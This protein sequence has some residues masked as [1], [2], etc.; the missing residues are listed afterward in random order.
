MADQGV[1]T[2]EKVMAT[3]AAVLASSLGFI[4]G[5][6]LPVAMPAIRADLGASFLASQWIA[7]GYMLFLS[8]LVLVGGAAGD[9]FG[10]REAFI[11]GILVFTLASIGCAIAGTAELLILFRCLQG[12]G[13]AVMVPGSLAL[14]ARV[15]P[16]EERGRAIGLWSTLSGLSPA[17]GPI[18]GGYLIETGGPAA[19]RMIFWINLPLAILAIAALLVGVRRLPSTP[20]GPIDWLG[21]LLATLSL[22]FLSYGLTLATEGARAAIAAVA[23]VVVGLAL[24]ALFLIQQRRTPHAMLPLDLFRSRLFRGANVLTF[25]LYLALGGVLY[26]LPITLI[27]ALHMPEAQAGAVFLPFTLA[28]A[29]V[30]PFAGAYADTHGPRLPIMVGCCIVSAAFVLLTGAVAFDAYFLGVLPAMTVLGIGMGLVVP[31]LSTTVMAAAGEAAV[32]A[33]SGINNG[34]ARVAGLFAVTVFGIVAAAI[35]AAMID[36]QKVPGG[37]GAPA[38]GLSEASERLRSAAMLAGFVAIGLSTAAMAGLSAFITWRMLP[39]GGSDPG[40]DG[41]A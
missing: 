35:F 20:Q 37:Y 34:V 17:L 3:L 28:L 40:P 30:A 11:V 14:I 22:G 18:L 41:Q 31:P 16:P 9:R 38:L 33:A 13:A 12:I 26:F 27:D 5:T 15:F 29:V 7:N 23:A 21:A 8:A 1:G 6:I 4:D 19:W 24:G 39:D 2:R 25:F 10:V 36:P 32:G